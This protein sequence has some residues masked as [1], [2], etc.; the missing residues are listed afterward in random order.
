MGDS[1][2]YNIAEDITTK[3]VKAV[4]RLLEDVVR[5]TY[6]SKSERNQVT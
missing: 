6:E 5:A 1:S 3:D 4:I 2:T